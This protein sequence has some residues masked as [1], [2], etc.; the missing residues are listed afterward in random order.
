MSVSRSVRE[1]TYDAQLE[2]ALQST[3]R[4]FASRS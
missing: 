4:W 1:P 2:E 3:Y